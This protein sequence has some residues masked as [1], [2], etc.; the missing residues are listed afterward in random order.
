M[1]QMSHPNP[2]WSVKKRRRVTIVTF[3]TM[4][5]DLKIM[6]MTPHVIMVTLNPEK[7][8]ATA[9]MMIPAHDP[10]GIMPYCYSIN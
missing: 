9:T 6:T 10:T 1:S 4:I 8:Y 2:K 3:V 7:I 5:S